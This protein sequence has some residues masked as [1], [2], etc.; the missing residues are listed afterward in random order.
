MRGSYVLT[1]KDEQMLQH[2]T[3][4]LQDNAPFAQPEVE[5]EALQECL[6]NIAKH[7]AQERMEIRE[8]AS[9][10]HPCASNCPLQSPMPRQ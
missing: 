2:V 3:E 6:Q 1:H 10:S 5:C 8:V 4:A 9:L 7:S